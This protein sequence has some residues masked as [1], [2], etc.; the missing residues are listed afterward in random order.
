MRKKKKDHLL[1]VF[2]NFSTYNL[3]NNCALQ[4][5]VTILIFFYILVLDTF[6]FVETEITGKKEYNFFWRI[7]RD[8]QEIK[9]VERMVFQITM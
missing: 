8:K 3:F 6:S 4:N 2:V 5:L 7:L 1:L 9:E